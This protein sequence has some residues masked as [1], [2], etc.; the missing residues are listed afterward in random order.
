MQFLLSVALAKSM[1]TRRFP[2]NWHLWVLFPWIKYKK[3]LSFLPLHTG[4]QVKRSTWWKNRVNKW[5]ETNKLKCRLVQVTWLAKRKSSSASSR[6]LRTENGA[7]PT[8]VVSQT[9]V[10]RYW[11]RLLSVP[12][13]INRARWSFEWRRRRDA[14]ELRSARCVG[15]RGSDRIVCRLLYHSLSATLYRC[16]SS[17]KTP[18]TA[19]HA[20]MISYKF[21]SIFLRY[22]FPLPSEKC[23]PS[24]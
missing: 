17:C 21:P 16:V 2:L 18:P 19:F 15:S 8:H 9:H 1:S 4:Q 6:L 20:A 3:K 7:R 12:A 22:F 23:V 10:A 14:K 24:H 13:D 11:H 5:I